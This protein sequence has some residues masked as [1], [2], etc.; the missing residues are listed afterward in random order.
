MYMHSSTFVYL[1]VVRDYR[2]M[3]IT[4]FIPELDNW[5]D[6][7]LASNSDTS[8]IASIARMKTDS[9]FVENKV[10]DHQMVFKDPLQGNYM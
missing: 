9:L 1:C 3:D 4:S 7:P 10:Q 5:F 2:E 6:S 8:G